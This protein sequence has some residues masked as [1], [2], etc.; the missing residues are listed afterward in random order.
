M[1]MY[2]KNNQLEIFDY[3]IIIVIFFQKAQQESPLE[4]RS[5]DLHHIHQKA[6]LNISYYT[7][8]VLPIYIVLITRPDHRHD[9]GQRN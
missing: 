7:V 6:G 9:Y 1:C 3:N 4:V 8:N 2:F 5:E